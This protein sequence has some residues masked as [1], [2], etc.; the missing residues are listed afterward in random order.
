VHLKHRHLCFFVMPRPDASLTIRGWMSQP[1]S[2]RLI[3]NGSV[4]TAAEWRHHD[5]QAAAKN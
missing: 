4:P 2:S 5:R 3:R 1:R